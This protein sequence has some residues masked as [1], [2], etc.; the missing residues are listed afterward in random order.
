MVSTF[1]FP[2]GKRSQPLLCINGPMAS[3]PPKA[4]WRTTDL[5]PDSTDSPPTIVDGY[6]LPDAIAPILISLT[7]DA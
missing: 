7:P 1:V 4:L 5:F 2:S 6:P 3:G